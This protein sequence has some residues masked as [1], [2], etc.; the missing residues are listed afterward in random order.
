MIVRWWLLLCLS[1][2]DGLRR[3]VRK[4]LVHLVNCLWWD[5]HGVLISSF[6]G[7]HMESRF[8]LVFWCGVHSSGRV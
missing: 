6:G 5:T 2:D 3:T 8:C 4:G 7:T 1:L